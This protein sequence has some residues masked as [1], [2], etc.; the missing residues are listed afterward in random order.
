MCK[1]RKVVTGRLHPE[2]NV[3]VQCPKC[4]GSGLATYTNY[5]VGVPPKRKL[6]QGVESLIIKAKRFGE[7]RASTPEDKRFAARLM[8][9]LTIFL[10][11]EKKRS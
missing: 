3:A 5:G 7:K 11:E 8:D 9:H 6:L 10:E 2:G 1:G 4:L